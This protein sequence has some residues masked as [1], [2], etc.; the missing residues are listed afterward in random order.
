MHLALWG[1][2]LLCLTVA[3]VTFFGRSESDLHAVRISTLVT[4]LAAAVVSAREL[5]RHRASY[6][7][8]IT[9]TGDLRLSANVP[10]NKNIP[11]DAAIGSDNV[12][13]LAAGSLITPVL[14][15]LRLADKH[16][17]IN[18]LLIFPD[19]VSHDA[20]RRLALA[21]RWLAAQRNRRQPDAF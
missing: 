5:L 11:I 16:D 1:L 15:I 20:F 18:T 19:S 10:V 7:L 3:L 2:S 8:D 9:G 6:L 17:N 12:Q 21:C 13:V 14:L 4:G